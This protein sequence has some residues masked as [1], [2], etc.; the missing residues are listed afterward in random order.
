MVILPQLISSNSSSDSV[1]SS[2]PSSPQQNDENLYEYLIV[3]DFEATCDSGSNPSISLSNNNQEMIEFPFVVLKLLNSSEVDYSVPCPRFV[4]IVHQ[5]QHYVIPE[6]TSNLTQFCT[7][8]TGITDQILQQFGEPLRKVIHGFDLYIQQNMKDKNFCIISDGEWDLKQLL[9]RES[10]NKQIPLL[11]HYYKFFDLRKEYRKCF[12][13][14][15]IRGLS[16]MVEHSGIEFVGKHHSGIDDCRTIVEL[17]NV[18]LG[19]GHTF[20]DPCVIDEYYDPFRDNSFSNFRQSSPPPSSHYH[21]PV[22]YN[23]PQHNYS[24]Y[25]SY[26]TI[27]YNPWSYPPLSKP[28]IKPKKSKKAKGKRSWNRNNVNSISKGIAVNERQ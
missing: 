18:L 22:H 7:E 21:L 25:P 28:Y 19:N 14:V 26:N 13:T 6:Y 5:E 11:S 2:C 17:I 23:E 15:P 16:T 1:V 20:K 10:K 8:L 3:I 4:Q 24:N 9:I 27:L 12:P